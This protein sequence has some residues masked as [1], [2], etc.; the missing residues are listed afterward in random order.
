MP[1]PA[2]YASEPARPPGPTPSRRVTGP[3]R[4]R[5]SRARSGPVR[6][7]P[8]PLGRAPIRSGAARGR[9]TMAGV[10]AYPAPLIRTCGVGGVL[11]GAPAPAAPVATPRTV[12]RRPVD[13]PVLKMPPP[14]AFAP[15]PWG[16]LAPARS[17]VPE[18]PRRPPAPH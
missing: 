17:D 15:S 7:A 3:P 6:V 4:S 13:M 12:V 18:R 14:C 10:D 8:E 9:A 2:P 5:P 11:A 1:R 16:P